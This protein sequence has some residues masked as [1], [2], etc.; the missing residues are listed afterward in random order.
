MER[1]LAI[2]GVVC[3]VISSVVFVAL[4]VDR[5][6]E[7]STKAIEPPHQLGELEQ[8]QSDLAIAIQQKQKCTESLD[9][10]LRV[11]VK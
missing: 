8:C 1:V 3:F 7:D 2:I 11:K 4:D 10:L 9:Q 5:A 6:Q